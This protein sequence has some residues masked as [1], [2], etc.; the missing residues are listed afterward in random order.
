MADWATLLGEGDFAGARAACQQKIAGRADSPEASWELAEV[1]ERWGDSL[2]FAGETGAAEHYHAA[3]TAL[4]P[5]GSQ[6]SSFE[7]NERRMGA[8]H[9]VMNKL[10]AIDPYGRPRPGHDGRPHPNSNCGRQLA[11]AGPQPLEL[12]IAEQRAAVANARET[13]QKQQAEYAELF[14]DSGHWCHY[15]LAGVY[16]IFAVG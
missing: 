5:P 10:C 11:K 3:R 13:T 6:F 9:R 12:S 4:V 1:E 8:Y 15:R 14:Q 2:F 7:E 16:K